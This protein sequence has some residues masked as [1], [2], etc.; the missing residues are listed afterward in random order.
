MPVFYFL[1]KWFHSKCPPKFLFLNVLYV[2][3]WINIYCV[4]QVSIIVLNRWNSQVEKL[5]N[6]TLGERAGIIWKFVWCVCV[7][8][9]CLKCFRWKFL[10]GQSL[11]MV[12]R[13]FLK[14]NLWVRSISIYTEINVLGLNKFKITC[15]FSIFN[16]NWAV[17]CK[18]NLT[19]TGKEV[20]R[21]GII[22]G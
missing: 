21:G 7:I 11:F 3:N 20:W 18:H 14:E 13:F 5:M 17:Q 2:R 19:S 22:N 12:F 9:D 6:I 8:C 4:F 16:K 10:W 15:Y 1:C